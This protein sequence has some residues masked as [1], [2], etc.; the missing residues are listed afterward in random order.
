MYI[1]NMTHFIN[2]TMNIPKQIPKEAREMA[3]F[4]SLVIDESTQQ[5]STSV[6]DTGIRCFRKNVSAPLIVSY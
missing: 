2:E 1:S 4:M 6:I 3:A 5:H